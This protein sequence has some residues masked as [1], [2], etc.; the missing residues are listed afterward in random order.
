MQ[1]CCTMGGINLNGIVECQVLERIEYQNFKVVYQG[2]IENKQEL[3]DWLSEEGYT[4]PNKND[5]ELVAHT[6][7][8]FYKDNL[9]NTVNIVLEKIKGSYGF[10]ITNSSV[11]EIVA[12][13]N[14]YPLVVGLGEKEN[15]IAFDLPSLLTYT[16]KCYLINNGEICTLTPGN[17][18]IVSPTGE[19]LEKERFQISWDGTMEKGNY[20][21]FMLKEIYE[22][23]G[24]FKTNLSGRIKDSK[25]R[26]EGLELSPEVVKRWRKITIVACGTSY[27]AG[28]I[29]KGVFEKL[30]HIPVEVEIAS[31][32]GYRGPLI[33]EETLVIVISQSG[34]T[35]DTLVA[36][37]EAKKKG[38]SVLAIT[39]VLNSTIGRE[40]DYGV[41]IWSGPEV[42]IASTKAFTAM[43]LTEYLLGIYLGQIKGSV[44]E[45]KANMLIEDLKNLPETASKILD[46]VDQ[47]QRIAEKYY[48]KE[49]AFFIG[50]GFDWPLSL[51][52]ALKLKE[53]S[54]IHA[55]GY[56]AG[57]FKH[58]SLALVSEDTL[59]ITLC[60]QKNTYE[61]TLANIKECKERGAQILAIAL[62][63]DQEI[64]KYADD[65]IYLPEIDNFVAPILTV[66]PLQLLAYN[67]SK[68]K[69]CNVDQPRN[70]VKSIV[71]E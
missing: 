27:H 46:Q 28:L 12:T 35:A 61:K 64:A 36:L 29:G 2:T 5:A 19:L 53:T 20:E 33:D 63:G 66:I 3:I 7:G 58:G 18:V 8:H 45:E 49:N 42:A 54:Y 14:N 56:A 62:E 44:S 31:E 22:Q 6:I 47:Y 41:Y 59:M 13:S 25:V 11:S 23:P 32:F 68:A 34:E 57:E 37:R 38:A 51:E 71:V 60:I 26:F 4:L 48:Q 30:L 55:E 17:L 52:G 16:N 9:T 24:G 69:D 21:H 43:L 40:A 70:L 50:R 65:V 10:A 67:I 1:L 39:N 15:F